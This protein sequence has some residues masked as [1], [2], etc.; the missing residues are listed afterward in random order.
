MHLGGFAEQLLGHPPVSGMS[1][2][3]RPQFHQPD[4]GPQVDVYL[5]ADAVGHGHDILSRFG[6]IRRDPLVGFPRALHGGGKG[7]LQSRPGDLLGHLIT[8]PGR[9]GLPLLGEH[10]VAVEVPVHAEIPGQVEGIEGQF[11]GAGRF[12]APVFP[13]IGQLLKPRGAFRFGEG[14]GPGQ[15]RGR[16]AAAAG[17]IKGGQHLPRSR[18]V[19][20]HQLHRGGFLRGVSSGSDG[21]LRGRYGRPLRESSEGLMVLLKTGEMPVGGIGPPHKRGNHLAQFGQHGPAQGLHLGQGG[22]LQP[23][24]Q[25]FEKTAVAI[26][27]HVGQRRGRQQTAQAI[28]NPG[29]HGAPPSRLAHA[30]IALGGLFHISGKRADHF[31]VGFEQRTVGVQV[32]LPVRGVHQRRFLVKQVFTIHFVPEKNIAGGF[33]QG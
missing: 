33:F 11:Q 20:I 2:G 7:R 10:P 18:R 13:Q 17:K 1:L 30:G 32:Q 31:P 8:Q 23:D 29:P 24:Q 16:I 19:P 4:Q 22:D 5:P 14:T 25:R 27:S 6:E 9:Q 21:A 3:R 26:D 28:E 12:V 15:Q